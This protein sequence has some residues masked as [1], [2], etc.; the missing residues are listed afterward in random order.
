MTLTDA[1]VRAAVQRCSELTDCHVKAIEPITGKAWRIVLNGP[2]ASVI[3]KRLDD[4]WGSAAELMRRIGE[5]GLAPRLHAYDLPTGI[6]LMEEL[7]AS[8]SACEVVQTA[9]QDAARKALEALGRTLA[10]LNAIDPRGLASVGP[11]VRTAHHPT[12][13]VDATSF[14][15]TVRQVCRQL[16]LRVPARL[17]DELQGAEAVLKAPGLL[18]A[19]H[20]DLCL[21]NF[22]LSDGRWVFVD[23]EWTGI[24]SVASDIGALAAHFPTCWCVRAIPVGIHT[25]MMEAYWAT[26][27]A[28]RGQGAAAELLNAVAPAVVAWAAWRC[29]GLLREIAE[30]DDALLHGGTITV[31]QRALYWL[32]RWITL[33]TEDSTQRFPEFTVLL[34]SMRDELCRRWGEAS[35]PFFD[36]FA[37]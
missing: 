24:R 36:G 30:P 37:K 34:T 11:V 8:R 32:E 14:A 23:L 33:L 6:A 1:A 18:G 16:S 13:I 21:D 9:H 4:P 26:Y 17:D 5:K 25:S 20:G 22:V 27:S 28:A 7:P 35:T 31:R 3:A 12:S 29:H 15:D 10:E 19:V 2:H